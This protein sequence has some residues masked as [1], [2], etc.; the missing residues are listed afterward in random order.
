[1]KK[2]IIKILIF[3]VPVFIGLVLLPVNKRTQY[4]E[5]KE[6]CFNHGI[7]IYDR[8]HNNPE[9][10]DIAILGS[11]HTINGINDGLI[12]EKLD[13]L[14]TVNFGYCRFGRN[15]HYSLLK[16]ILTEKDIKKLIIEV[17]RGE[18]RYSH[19]IYPF[20]ADTKD[21]FLNNS[22]ANREIFQDIWNHLAYKLE[23]F[24][25][26]I[27]DQTTKTGIRNDDF[28]F[29]SNPDTASSRFLD[30]VKLKKS[31]ADTIMSEFQKS[32]QYKLG[33]DFQ[34]KIAKLC[35]KHHIEIFYLFI[36]TYGTIFTVPKELKTYQ[37]YGKVLLPPT[38]IYDNQDFW[39]DEGHLNIAGANELSQWL[40]EQLR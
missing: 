17:R 31:H 24:K 25:D 21:L 13:S 11:S 34:K 8:I 30:E 27:Y 12:T 14:N 1:M 29:A 10:I 4:V 20:I 9:K 19:P 18:N 35:D 36:P 37:K 23:L 3:L 15:F 22:L 40:A 16:E 32:V 38:Y 2:L 26:K 7:W 5:L 33:R 28:G 6:D 39:F